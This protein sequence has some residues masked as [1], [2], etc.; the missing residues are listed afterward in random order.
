MTE[1]AGI[2]KLDHRADAIA[3]KMVTVFQ[4]SYRIEGD[5]IGMD[6]FPPL[7]RTAADLQA[8]DAMFFG[9]WCEGELAAA[10]E[11]TLEPEEELSIHSLVVD[12]AFFRRGLAGRLL[13]FVCDRLTWKTAVVDT[14]IVNEPAIALYRKYGFSEVKRWTPQHG[15]PKILLRRQAP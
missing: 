10:I 11:V 13:C 3:A 8:S 2:E 5:L 15:I 14:A 4:R 6:D 9:A 7:R 1:Q 12:P